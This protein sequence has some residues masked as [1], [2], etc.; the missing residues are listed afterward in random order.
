[1]KRIGIDLGGTKIQGI[2]LA[3]DGRVLSTR[4]AATPAQSYAGTVA[5]IVRMVAELDGESGEA[6]DLPVGI[7]TPGIWMAE[8]GAMKNCNST[9]LN[10]QPLL[11]DL[12]HALGPRVRLANDADCFALSEALAGTGWRILLSSVRRGH[13]RVR[14]RRGRLQRL[15]AHRR[16]PGTQIGG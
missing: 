7:G 12:E 11:L 5:A 15:G 10:G 2:V 6:D 14:G 8:R 4:R 3:E 16:V 9:W 1:M 13:A